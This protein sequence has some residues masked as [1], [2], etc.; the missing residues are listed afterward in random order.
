MNS[1]PHSPQTLE[2]FLDVL[3]DDVAPLTRAGVGSGNKLFG[4]A[5]VRKSDLA[6]VIAATNAETENPLWHGE[7]TCLNAY[8]ALDVTKR[9]PPKDCYFLSTHE[10]CSLCLS[11]ITWSGFDNFFYLFS[12]E[13]SRD[14]FAIPHD[15]R[16]L[17]EVFACKNGGYKSE[18]A[19]WRAYALKDL[20]LKAGPTPGT[21]K[22]LARLADMYG[23]FSAD[24]QSRKGTAGIPLT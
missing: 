9:P 11:A 13:D 15:L 3:L 12:Y 18:N 21:E 23:Q 19:Y 16:I 8:W 14:L 7:V 10:P 20:I 17:E 6:L 4:A 2:R 1:T 22:K 24:Y 5:I